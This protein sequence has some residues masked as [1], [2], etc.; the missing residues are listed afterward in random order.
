MPKELQ[1]THESGKRE[2][3]RLKGV[4]GNFYLEYKLKS[5]TRKSKTLSIE[6]FQ[7]YKAPGA[8]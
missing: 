2:A 5:L 7:K 6:R 3:S 4:R 1:T 8:S